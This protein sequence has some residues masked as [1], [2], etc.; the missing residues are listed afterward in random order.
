MAG[1]RSVKLAMVRAAGRPRVV[2]IGFVLD[3]DDLVVEM[4]I[5]P[6]KTADI[7]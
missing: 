6:A 5:G 4:G 3:G 2:P 7:R 1:T